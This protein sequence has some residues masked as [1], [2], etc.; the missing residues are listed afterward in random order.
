MVVLIIEWNHV[1]KEPVVD[2]HIMNIFL[3]SSEFPSCTS[4]IHKNNEVGRSR[5]PVGKNKPRFP[6][7]SHI[8]MYIYMR[9]KPRSSWG[10]GKCTIHELHSQ[11][12][13]FYMDKIFAFANVTLSA[14]C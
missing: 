7:L 1:Y 13:Y 9:I 2:L 4:A 11:P 5:D 12:S 3:L 8:H 10:W 6:R 14:R